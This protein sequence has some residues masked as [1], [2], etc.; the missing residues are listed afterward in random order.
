[1]YMLHSCHV[2]TISGLTPITSSQVYHE[3]YHKIPYLRERVTCL[4][5]LMN[6]LDPY[7]PV[8]LLIIII[9]IIIIYMAP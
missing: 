8:N 5:P 6:E 9:I 2:L 1:M 7:E 4:A 3:L